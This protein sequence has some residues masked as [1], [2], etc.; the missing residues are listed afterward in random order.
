MDSEFLQLP[1]R[2]VSNLQAGY[3]HALAMLVKAGTGLDRA[4]TELDCA[5]TTFRYAINEYFNQLQLQIDHK[6][7][8]IRLMM[9]QKIEAFDAMYSMQDQLAKLRA[10]KT[11]VNTKNENVLPRG[12]LQENFPGSSSTNIFYPL[13]YPNSQRSQLA[14]EILTAFKI[15]YHSRPRIERLVHHP[16]AQTTQP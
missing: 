9:E 15:T 14:D 13:S 12:M 16:M 1:A 8:A 10:E 7:K 6:D 5:Q 4:G 11:M 2:G 3:D